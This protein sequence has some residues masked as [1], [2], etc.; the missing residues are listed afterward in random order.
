MS[1]IWREIKQWYKDHGFPHAAAN[2]KAIQAEWSSDP[3]TL[4]S[5]LKQCA[6]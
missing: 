2:M 1:A 3:S 5:K 4:L 6:R